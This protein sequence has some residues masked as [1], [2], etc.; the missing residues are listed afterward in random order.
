MEKISTVFVR[1]MTEGGWAGWAQL[2][3]HQDSM[4]P[5]AAQGHLGVRPSASRAAEIV[6]TERMKVMV[7]TG[8]GPKA[9]GKIV[10]QE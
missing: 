3:Q 8:R 7:K 10:K 2:L 9:E 4:C 1:S 6:I 5:E